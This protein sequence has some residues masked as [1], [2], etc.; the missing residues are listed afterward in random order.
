MFPYTILAIG[1]DPE[2]HDCLYEVVRNYPEYILK[3]VNSLK[4][5]V[6]SWRENSFQA[7]W[8][9]QNYLEDNPWI[10]LLIEEVSTN[11]YI[12]PVFLVG[13]SFSFKECQK[14]FSE[15]QV[16]IVPLPLVYEEIVNQLF[17]HTYQQFLMD[18]LRINLEKSKHFSQL[19]VQLNSLNLN[20]I[21]E[22]VLE[23]IT[24][25]LG[26]T[27]V[28]IWW[29]EKNPERFCLGMH[30]DKNFPVK[31][32][33]PDE[34]TWMWDALETGELLILDLSD[35]NDKKS[36]KDDK[37]TGMALVA[38][39]LV[40]NERLGVINFTNF[41]PKFF[42]SYE[43]D[44]LRFLC[45][46][47]TSRIGHALKH[48]QTLSKDKELREKNKK[49]KDL[50]NDLEK[51]LD[52][53]TEISNNLITT[54]QELD[55]SKNEQEKLNQLK[56]E[57]LA[58]ASHDL[59]SPLGGIHAAVET[60]LTFFEL[61]EEAKE[62]LE[63]VLGLCNQQMEVINNFLDVARI[64]SGQFDLEYSELSYDVFVNHIK[65]IE[66]NFLP[67]TRSKHIAL[68][69]YIDE[70]L[71]VVYFDVPKIKQVI[72]N[73]ISNAVKF[74]PENG[75][76]FLKIKKNIFDDDQNQKISKDIN[77]KISNIFITV[78]DT[79]I[80][81]K[82]DDI[83]YIFDKYKQVKERNIGTRGEKGTGLG[84]AICKNLVELH[85]GKI[86]VESKLGFGTQFHFSLPVNPIKNK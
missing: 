66:N 47:I 22:K 30:S 45:T 85:G 34:S 42:K 31:Y 17:F 72:N 50:N 73:L 69:A 62:I 46:H 82:E 13:N 77:K 80:G 23:F 33:N 25:V 19:L 12:A 75:K 55:K 68:V 53:Q 58:I 67:I 83:D 56:N 51:L 10:H 15:V 11:N 26:I 74:T 60:L 24:Q 9:N 81:I 79:G 41:S 76:I 65:N 4:D 35:F 63:P 49:L 40:E 70:D 3:V 38:P 84:L 37:R 54:T 1:D 48:Q 39:L 21:C 44:D 61:E 43:L 36:E 71:P 57:F 28:S 29:L 32:I 18:S 14:L 16:E 86:W 59:R 20:L 5:A 52:I 7:F 6:S 2:S 8:I 78:Q 27:W 64:E